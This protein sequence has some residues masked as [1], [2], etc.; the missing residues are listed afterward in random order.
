[1]ARTRLDISSPD[2]VEVFDTAQQRVFTLAELSGILQ[3]HRNDWRLAMRTTTANFA[4]FLERKGLKTIE[5]DFLHPGI[6]SIT[7]YVWK[8]VSPYE[9]GQS[10]RERA[11][12][13]HGTAVFSHALTD[14]L[15]KTIYVNHEQSPKP[16]SKG[17]LVQQ[18][19]DR[20]FASKQRQTQAIANYAGDRQFV[21]LNGKNT[22]Q[23]GVEELTVERAKLR[24]TNIERTLID[25]VVRPSY[26]GGVFQV[27]NAYRRAKDRVSVATLLMYLKALD[28]VYPYHQAIGFYMQKAGYDAKRYDRLK[29]LGLKHDFYLAHDMGEKTYIKDWRLHIPKRFEN[30]SSLF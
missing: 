23:L 3:A 1:M 24:V 25:I 27:L 20:A 28:Y 17:V 18:N 21:L 11:Y 4:S 2:I 12:L 13:S 7:R 5:I 22:G 10:L 26:A 9:V 19:I 14:E 8:E 30:A 6:R 29:K 16:A 15:P